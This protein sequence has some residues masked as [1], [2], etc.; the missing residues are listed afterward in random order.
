M[1]KQYRKGEGGTR[2]EWSEMG[3]RSVRMNAT[4]CD[5]GLV[6][7]RVSFKPLLLSS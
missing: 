4:H 2:G 7:N 3:H 6:D 5:L 1:G